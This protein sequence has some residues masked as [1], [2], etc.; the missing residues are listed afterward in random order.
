MIIG[1]TFSQYYSNSSYEK[2]LVSTIVEAFSV[3]T[4]ITAEQVLNLQIAQN[5][6]RRRLQSSSSSIFASYEIVTD[7]KY[8]ATTYSTQ[9]SNSVS[10]GQF[11]AT[12]RNNAIL[13]GA[14]L[15]ANA[16]SSSVTVGNEQIPFKFRSN[17]VSL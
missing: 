13:N 15:F 2:A 6:G 12:L 7:S 1:L 9:L 4:N 8:S 10:S 14:P 11:T 16:T 5:S 3:P 17:P